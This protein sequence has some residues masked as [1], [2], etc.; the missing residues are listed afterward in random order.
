M[1]RK[2]F[3]EKWVTVKVVK[4]FEGNPRNPVRYVET[5]SPDSLW[6]WIEQYGTEQRIDERQSIIKL[7]KRIKADKPSIGAKEALRTV[8]IE[9]GEE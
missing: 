7:I 5:Y 6:Q 2:E 9:L 8:L 4:Q 1:D 3:E